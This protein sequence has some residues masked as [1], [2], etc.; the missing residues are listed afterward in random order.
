VR[1]IRVDQNEELSQ[2]ARL[3]ADNIEA[4]WCLFVGQSK[5]HSVRSGEFYDQSSEASDV[6]AMLSPIKIHISV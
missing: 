3:I 2:E 4:L 5:S 1:L 6:D